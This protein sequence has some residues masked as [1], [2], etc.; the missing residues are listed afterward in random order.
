MKGSIIFTT[1]V[2]I[3]VITIIVHILLLQ[4]DD[5]RNYIGI[6]MIIPLLVVLLYQAVI[7]KMKVEYSFAIR[8]STFYPTVLAILL[9]IFLGVGLQLYFYFM[10]GEYFLFTTYHELISLLFIGMTISTLSAL[11]EEIVW[12]GNYYE[13]LRRKYSFIKTALITASIWSIWHLP[14]AFFYK[15]YTHKFMGI[16]IYLLLLFTIS[17][18]LTYIREKG[19]SVIPAAILHG[20]LNVFY[21]HDPTPGTIAVEILDMTKWV[22]FVVT[23]IILFMLVELRATKV[24]VI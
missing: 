20:M 19:D 5:A 3:Y 8:K 10:Y 7:K 23:C 17:I 13:Y 16:V 4:L 15:T 14:I 6:T 18:I 22:V 12:R 9:P 21:L 11:L 24:R 2:W 1:T